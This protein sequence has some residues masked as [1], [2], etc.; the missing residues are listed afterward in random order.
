MSRIM[1]WNYAGEADITLGKEI[2][3]NPLPKIFLALTIFVIIS[4]S[5]TAFIFRDT[6]YDMIVNPQIV[7]KAV[8]PTDSGFE[9]EVP[10]QFAFTP[11][12]FIDEINTR[13]YDAFLDP[14]NTEYIYSVDG[15]VDTSI[16]GDYTIVYNS[17]NRTNS[18]QISLTVKVTDNVAPIL[19]LQNPYNKRELR[20]D[21]TGEYK[22][23]I[24]VRDSDSTYKY[25]GE[26]DFN[27]KNFINKLEDNYST[28]DKLVVTYPDKPSFAGND[29][30]YTDL[31]YS[32]KDESDN[33]T[34]VTVN[35]I[36]INIEDIDKVG[37]E[38]ADADNNT[39]P[40][41]T[42]SL[43]DK[44]AAIAE[45]EAEKQ[46]A[47]NTSANN[48][49]N[50]HG[51]TADPGNGAPAINTDGSNTVQA[52]S[53]SASPFSWSVSNDGSYMAMIAAAQSRVVYYDYDSHQVM[54][55]SG[56]FISFQPEG[57]GTYTIHWQCTSCELSCD[58]SVTITE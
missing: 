4:A 28:K 54:C 29:V 30:I 2:K 14:E 11:E 40:A 33:I 27:I 43:D 58:Q 42:S 18:Q 55:T 39:S 26:N 52:R 45:Q 50:N 32:V 6:L 51:S 47:Q 9:V 3:L 38:T 44:I 56:P 24:V 16:L 13:E 53:L 5:L 57:P 23:V 48:D 37:I 17:N 21:E 7:L 25:L 49:D 41:D 35:L 1:K 10:Y 8:N 46:H 34:E 20:K 22:P 31:V 19:T 12:K 36:I 15:S